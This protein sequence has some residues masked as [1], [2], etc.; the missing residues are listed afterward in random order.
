[1]TTCESL[2]QQL[3]AGLHPAHLEIVDE[4]SKHAGHYQPSSSGGT[5]FKILIV[6]AAF[7]GLTRIQRHQ[8]VYALLSAE[9]QNSLHAL[10]L[11]TLTP[12]EYASPPSKL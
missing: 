7:K 8:R 6:S 3:I 4:S 10:S 9:F 2:R 12:E 5:H 1:M 11:Q